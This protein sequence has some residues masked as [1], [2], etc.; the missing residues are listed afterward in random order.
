MKKQQKKK[1]V[2]AFGVFDLLHPGHLTFLTAARALGDELVVVIT[3]DSR[4]KKEKGAAPVFT[5]KE[6]L[7]M[8]SALSVVTHVVLGDRPG[9]WS[10]LEKLKPDIVAIGHDQ[11]RPE[12][13]IF[14]ARLVM[15]QAKNRK[16]YS[17]SRIR[18]AFAAI[19]K[20]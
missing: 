18:S 19:S 8:I 5:E 20:L 15:I 13:K 1:R 6:R 12:T 4:V 7:Q 9:Q 17:S 2:V 16:R 10:M 14:S 11:K 3:R